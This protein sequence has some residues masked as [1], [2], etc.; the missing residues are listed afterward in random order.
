MERTIKVF[1]S[2]Y[3]LDRYER[4]RRRAMSPEQRLLELESIR[5]EAGRFLYEHSA[6]LRRVV[7]VTGK[8]KQLST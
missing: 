5:S 2:A 7:T 6:R 1:K 4:S 3:E 8:T